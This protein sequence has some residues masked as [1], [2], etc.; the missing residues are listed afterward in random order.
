MDR[1]EVQLE[2][3]RQACEDRRQYDGFIWQNTIASAL[4]VLAGAAA[5]AVQNVSDGV[6]GGT[7]LG[8]AILLFTLWHA[9][10]KHRFGTDSRTE[11]LDALEV[12][13][14]KDG[15]VTAKVHRRTSIPAEQ[16]KL[17]VVREIS[18]IERM[19]SVW[20]LKRVMLSFVL[21]LTG[22]AVVYLLAAAGATGVP[23]FL[24]PPATT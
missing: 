2:Q 8:L 20:L 11:F 17:T 4:T 21:V 7:L 23:H 1:V 12:S 22:L 3:Y 6:R 19:S 15:L 18:G 16:S 9:L 14:S 13:W 24:K 5:V 10:L